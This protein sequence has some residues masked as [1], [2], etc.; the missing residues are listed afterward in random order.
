[1]SDELHMQLAATH[2]ITEIFSRR[3]V[4]SIIN[5]HF[6]VASLELDYIEK[7]KLN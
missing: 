7:L 2:V 5:F 1:M 4:V 6:Y 3:H